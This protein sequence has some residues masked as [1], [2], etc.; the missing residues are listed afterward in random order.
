MKIHNHVPLFAPMAAANEATDRDAPHGSD[1][2]HKWFLDTQV[3]AGA[4]ALGGGR[5]LLHQL[6][7]PVEVLLDDVLPN[8]P[9]TPVGRAWAACVRECIR[10][11]QSDVV[12][13]FDYIEYDTPAE[14]QA[15]HAIEAY[16]EQ[17]E[18]TSPL[19]A[20]VADAVDRMTLTS[21]YRPQVELAAVARERSRLTDE[22]LMLGT[23]DE[24]FCKED[25]AYCYHLD[26][27]RLVKWAHMEAL[28]PGFEA[29]L[30]GL[31]ATLDADLPQVAESDGAAARGRDLDTVRAALTA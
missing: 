5:S 29:T 7:V 25:Q 31:L 28:V 1:A 14:Q 12:R 2:F 17:I 20:E 30:R 22:G 23:F 10:L 11:T 8:V 4:P 24:D 13:P 26:N 3:T 21:P 9:D 27:A 18:A 16:A 19:L 6:S 15:L